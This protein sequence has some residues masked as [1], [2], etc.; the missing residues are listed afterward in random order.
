MQPDNRTAEFAADDR[1]FSEGDPAG[2]MYFVE[3]GRVEIRHQV[4]GREETL[5]EINQGQFFGEMALF[6][7]APRS[8]S[9]VAVRDSRLVCYTRN[10][11]E[12]AIR[13]DPELAIFL[14][15]DLC[16]RLR[17]ADQYLKERM[18]GPDSQAGEW[19]ETFLTLRSIMET[20]IKS[21]K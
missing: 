2:V 15:E 12:S 16:V 18:H 13:S 5:A 20:R 11:F 8:A 4:E 14:I 19:Q 10:E 21:G 7:D 6:G 17:K 1:I 9:A 3:Q